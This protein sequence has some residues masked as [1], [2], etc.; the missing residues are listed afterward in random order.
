MSL[1]ESQEIVWGGH[2][3]WKVLIGRKFFFIFN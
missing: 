1:L 2:G 3:I